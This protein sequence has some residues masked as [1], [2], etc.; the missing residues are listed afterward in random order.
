MDW[1]KELIKK[2]PFVSLLIPTGIGGFSFFGNLIAAMSDGQIDSMEM[3][4]LMSSADAL[5]TVVL[6]VVMFALK[7]NKNK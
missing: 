4:Q 7:G 6:I 5:Q 1:L 3:H 2:N